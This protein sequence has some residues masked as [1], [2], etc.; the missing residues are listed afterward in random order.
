[1]VFGEGTYHKLGSWYK[2]LV[3]IS[4]PIRVEMPQRITVGTKN[5]ESKEW[6]TI[7]NENNGYG[8]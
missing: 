2:A 7:N 3:V 1:M 8:R 5:M 6:K 4:T